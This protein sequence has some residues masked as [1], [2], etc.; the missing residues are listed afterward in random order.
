MKNLNLSDK[1]KE[2]EDQLRN[3]I[4]MDDYDGGRAAMLR[5]VID[6]LKELDGTK[7]QV[8]QKHSEYM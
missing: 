7:Q 1:I 5:D 8:P 3:L 6:D 4:P 2:Y